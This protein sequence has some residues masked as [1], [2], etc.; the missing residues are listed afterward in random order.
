MKD[1][2]DD[3]L[4]E[5]KKSKEIGD[6]LIKK[7][8]GIET[9]AHFIRD[10]A[11][12]S[13]W[14]VTCVS[15]GNNAN[16]DFDS[17]IQ[18]Y[19]KQNERLEKLNANFNFPDIFAVSSSANAVASTMV[20][21]ADP[22]QL[23]KL[24][25]HNQEETQKAAINLG[26][27]IDR[28]AEK[29]KVLELLNEF[30]LSNNQK[31]A[32]SPCELFE[33]A[34]AAFETP[35]IQGNPVST[36]LIPMRECMNSTLAILLRRRPMQEKASSHKDKIVSICKQSVYSGIDNNDIVDIAER[37]EELSA[38]LSGAKQGDISKAEWRAIMRKAMLL[39][40]GLLKIL[41]Q[42]KMR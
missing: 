42:T 28:L 18:S 20:T 31:G 36:S 38:I 10:L 12:A 16:L 9:E 7:A 8:K 6:S 27:V 5:I 21:F 22:T 34:C 33:T 32:K 4:H 1:P 39:L 23:A 13:E 15:S 11:D 3:L 30:G 26:Q 40:I 24:I 17:Q 14:A 35:L 29:P 2:K 41:D 19:R 25:T 37:W